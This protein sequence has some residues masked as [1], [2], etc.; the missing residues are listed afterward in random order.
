MAKR[1]LNK[2][3]AFIGS[4]ILVVLLVGAIWVVLDLSRDPTQFLEDGDAAVLA[5]DYEAAST[6]Y[7][8]AFKRADNDE[9]RK[10]ILFKPIWPFFM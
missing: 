4:A 3:V 1:R 2:K 10:E 6:S 5:K 9:T 7:L 8:A